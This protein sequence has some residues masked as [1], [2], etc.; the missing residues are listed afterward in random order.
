MGK[1]TKAEL[2]EALATAARMREKGEDEHYLAKSLLNMN[3]RFRYLEKV[4]EAAEYF[5]LTG[6]DAHKH[7]QLQLAIDAARKAELQSSGEDAPELPGS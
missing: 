1:P 2:D 5:L 4:L 7:T 6:Q 3:Y